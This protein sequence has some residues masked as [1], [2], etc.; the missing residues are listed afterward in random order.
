M[1]SSDDPA[2]VDRDGDGTKA[3][4][5]C[6]DLDP[7]RYHLAPEVLCDG[8]DQNCD[9]SDQC[10][11]DGDGYWDQTDCDPRDPA[12]TDQCREIPPAE[13]SD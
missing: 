10:D 4:W 5:D 9:G 8:L 1:R 11:A 7:T 12:V 13:P 3:R 2:C 6:D